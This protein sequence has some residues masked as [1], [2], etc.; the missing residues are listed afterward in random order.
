MIHA[1]GA[2]MIALTPITQGIRL[3]ARVMNVARLTRAG[4]FAI[5]RLIH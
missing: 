5:F 2:E 1:A 3:I 4:V